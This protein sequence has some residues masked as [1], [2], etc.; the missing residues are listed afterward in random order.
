VLGEVRR[1]DLPTEHAGS[2]GFWRWQVVLPTVVATTPPRV[3][4]H[5]RSRL[6]VAPSLG[7]Q[8]VAGIAVVGLDARVK[9]PLPDWRPALVRWPSRCAACV[10]GRVLV[11]CIAV[12][13]RVGLMA[14]AGHGALGLLHDR[15]FDKGLRLA[16]QVACFRRRWFGHGSEQRCHCDELLT[17]PGRRVRVVDVEVGIDALTGLPARLSH[18]FAAPRLLPRWWLAR[19]APAIL[20]CEFSLEVAC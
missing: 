8:D 18:V 3:V 7:I 10:D 14:Y 6:R 17:C 1:A 12:A 4:A 9:D 5:R 15:L 16:A 11:L 13:L 2:R 19:A 20:I